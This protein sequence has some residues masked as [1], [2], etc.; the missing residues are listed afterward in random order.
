MNSESKQIVSLVISLAIVIAS[1]GST[2]ALKGSGTA[3]EKPQLNPLPT[4][5]HSSY[6]V[7]ERERELRTEHLIRGEVHHLPLFEER[8]GVTHRRRGKKNEAA[9]ATAASK[10]QGSR[11]PQHRYPNPEDNVQNLRRKKISKASS[12][13]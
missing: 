2:S 4:E 11:R 13:A 5:F 1:Y 9:A 12:S 6:P 7:R 3:Q 8:V 10:G